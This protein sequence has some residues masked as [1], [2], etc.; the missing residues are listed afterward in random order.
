VYGGLGL[1]VNFTYSDAEADSGDPIPG[2]SR[3]SYNL[4]AFFENSRLSTRLA[5]TYRSAFFVTFDRATPL[6]QT[7]L[8]SLDAS[9]IFSINPAGR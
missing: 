1:Q 2:N 4:A 6:N 3:R 5:Y 8:E 7:E 9:L